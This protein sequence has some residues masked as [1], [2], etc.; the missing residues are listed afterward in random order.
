MSKFIPNDKL[1]SYVTIYDNV[2]DEMHRKSEAPDN[3]ESWC[4][5]RYDCDTSNITNKSDTRI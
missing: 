5:E 1:K 2:T 4:V 3:W